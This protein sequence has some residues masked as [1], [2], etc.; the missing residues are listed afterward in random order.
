MSAHD[1]QL[2]YRLIDEGHPQEKVARVLGVSRRTVYRHLLARKYVVLA[3]HVE[4]SA[5]QKASL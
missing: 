5:I 2:L 3:G 4:G 1:R